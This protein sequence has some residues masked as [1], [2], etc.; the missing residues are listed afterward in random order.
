[1][2][3]TRRS[4]QVVLGVLWVLDGLL[5][6]QPF[7][8]GTGFGALILGTAAAGQPTFVSVPLQWV[9]ELVLAHHVALD[10]AFG[11]FQILMGLGL[12]VRPTVRA[13]LAASVA[14]GLAVWYLG[15][16]LGG[17]ASGHTSIFTGAPGSALLYAILALVAWPARAERSPERTS[18]AEPPS[19]WISRI[20]RGGALSS[21]VPPRSW[22][23]VAWTVL[24][25]GGVVLLSLPSQAS[26]DALA[27]GPLALAQSN[28]S[29]LAGWDYTVANWI[30]AAGNGLVV[31]L[32]VLEALIGL[33][34][35]FG[36]WPRRVAL[37]LGICLALTD[38]VIGQ[39][40]GQ[41]A[42]G[43]ATDPNSGPMLVLLGIAVLASGARLRVRAP[44]ESPQEPP[45]PLPCLAPR[46]SG[47]G[48][49][50]Q[51]GRG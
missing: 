34:A 24:W 22:V 21:D 45:G 27:G 23:A 49:S 50:T 39:G 46:P 2:R 14:W 48:F 33:V 30:L 42:S 29:W 17:I 3:V 10:A 51:P 41:L 36:G 1:M 9:M 35:L 6:L 43:Q 44:A 32:A 7:M 13:A 4:I 5:Q 38:W 16:G 12:L 37:T 26:A 15:E 31:G 20:M 8:L 28:P 40:F 18:V 25:L 11:T 19:S 47:P